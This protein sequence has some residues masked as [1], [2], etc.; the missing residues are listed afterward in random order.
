MKMISKILGVVSTVTLISSMSIAN[1]NIKTAHEW[2]YTG[3]N[4]PESWGSISPKNKMCAIGK[5]QSPINITTTLH[6]DLDELK[7]SYNGSS[8]KVVNNGHTIEVVVGD[9]NTIV[10]DKMIFNLKQFHFHS[11]SENKIDGK[12]FPLEGHF[13]NVDKDGNIAVIAVM[14]EYGKENKVLSK[15]WNKMPIKE[16]EENK[17]E[18]KKIA[19]ELLP[20]NMAHYHF[21]GS[22]T[23]PPCTEGVRW[24]VLKTPVTV[25]KE[26]VKKFLNIMKHTNNRPVQPVNARV[27]I[28]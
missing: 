1:E 8:N 25:S 18:L 14:F 6:I 19:S 26:Q 7:I 10:L 16:G 5:N 4:S 12:S 17:L 15:I 24:I 11:P 3:H 28:D 2:G 21:N 20:T 13:V 23:T 9:D 27:V 22:L